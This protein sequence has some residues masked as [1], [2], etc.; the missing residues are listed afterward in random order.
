MSVMYTYMAY[1][2]TAQIG[3]LYDFI[4]FIRQYTLHRQQSV[5]RKVAESV[6]FI[7]DSRA[8]TLRLLTPYI[9]CRIKY[10]TG[11]KQINKQAYLVIRRKIMVLTTN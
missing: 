3:Y 4:D 5:L 7:V 10:F 11:L 2:S 1:Y 9:Q 8:C 6:V